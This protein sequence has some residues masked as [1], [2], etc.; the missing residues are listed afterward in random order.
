MLRPVRVGLEIAAALST[1]FKDKF[2]LSTSAHLLGSQ[3]SFDRVMRG[4]DPAVVA[5]SWAAD[6]ARWRRVREKYLLY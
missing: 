2:D 4:E 1:L 3:D 6:E 5:K